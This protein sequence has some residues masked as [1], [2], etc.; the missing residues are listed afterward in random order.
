MTMASMK[1]SYFRANRNRD[2]ASFYFS[3]TEEVTE[4]HGKIP[5]EKVLQQLTG[6]SIERDT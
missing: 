1:S 5:T 4:N 6:A 3:G 2:F